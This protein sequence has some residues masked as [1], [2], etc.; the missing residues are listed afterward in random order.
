MRIRPATHEDCTAIT[1]FWNPF[2]RRS[3]VTFNS[4]EKT[5][6]ELAAELARKSA[7]NQPFLVAD[8][9]GSILGFA[10]YGQFR[11][12]NG[13]RLTMEHTIILAPEASGKGIGREL[14]QRIEDHAR[15]RGVHSMLAGISHRNPQGI[16]FHAALGYSEIARLP[17]VGVKFDRWFDLVLMQKFL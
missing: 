17:E 1:A 4:I 10:T 6:A 15:E 12:S 16:A 8:E 2:I 7:A 3:E 5:P 11:A 13:Y 14:M 9:A